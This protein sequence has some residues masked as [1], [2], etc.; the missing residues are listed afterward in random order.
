MD[1]SF[2]RPPVARQAIQPQL[3]YRFHRV[4][5]AAEHVVPPDFEDLQMLRHRDLG[6]ECPGWRE[7]RPPR[8]I[9]RSARK[10][11]HPRLIVRVDYEIRVGRQRGRERD[12]GIPLLDARP[13]RL[14]HTGTRG[15]W[16][17]GL[18]SRAAPHPRCTKSPAA[19][20]AEL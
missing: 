5:I 13:S 10:G 2:H 15:R 8:R 20:H 14:V 12:V 3:G 16:V 19:L 18:I 9:I 11:A 17:P 6:D 4:E 7:H 1:S